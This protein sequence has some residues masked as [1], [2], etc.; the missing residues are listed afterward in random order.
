M[1]IQSLDLV[2]KKS[3]QDILGFDLDDDRLKIVHVRI[4]GLKREVLNLVHREV[5]GM[6]D[7]EIAALIIQSLVDLKITNP[8][9][10]FCM[11]LNTLIT[12]I[13]EIPSRDAEEIREIVSLQAS[14]HTPYSRSEIIIDTLTLGVVRE[15]YTKVLLVIA[16]REIVIRQ[17][18]ILEKAHLKVE[19]V[20]FPPEGICHA[21]VKILSSE[22][23]D[24]PIA[25][26]HMDGSFTS[27]LVIQR[28]KILFV[29]GISI[30]ADHLLEEKEIYAGRFVDE[31]QKSLEAY[32]HDEAGLLPSQLLLTGVVA[33]VNALDDLFR[34]TLNIPI[35]HQTYFNH[36][37]ISDR[38][39]AVASSS[40]QVSFFNVITPLL[41]YDRMKIDLNSEEQKIKVQLEHRGKEMMKTGVLVM[42]L[43]ALIFTFFAAKVYL[44]NSY[45]NSLTKRYKSVKAD[46]KQ[47]EILFEK[48]QVI[49]KYLS[50]RGDSLQ[51]LSELYELMPH[52]VSLN[53][54]RYE[55]GQHFSFKGTSAAMGSVFSFVANLEKSKLFK[56]VKTK[57][58]TMRSEGRRD[59]VDFEITALAGN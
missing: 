38:A 6:T 58:V 54:I 1:A 11:P 15:S 7:D 3:R 22:N 30:G 35:K 20:F 40:K 49:K 50:E 27:F 46:A 59:I 24:S 2:R 56:E 14:R 51:V 36:F 28:S 9:T 32:I 16:P 52:D 21:C 43:L 57:Y 13:I 55:E 44:R 5:R 33:E 42:I 45:F 4:A 37:A 18:K 48:V 17:T 41:L 10:F 31:L 26:L 47:L 34:S 23:N 39:K 53:D 12:R 29:R 8:R 19:K 25:I